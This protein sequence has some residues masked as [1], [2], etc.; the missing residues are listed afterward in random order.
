M[1]EHALASVMMDTR[2][3][4]SVRVEEIVAGLNR[5]QKTIE[6]KYF[7]DAHGS[8]LFEAITELPEYYLTRT[9]MR[10]L[11]THMSEIAALL[12]KQVCVI[13]Y[14]AGSSKKIRLLMDGLSPWAYVPIDISRDFLLASAADLA[15][16]YPALEIFPVCA[17]LSLPLQLP[18]PVAER[19][20]LGFYPGSSIGNFEPSAARAFLQSVAHTLGNGNHLLIGVDRKKPQHLLEAAYNDAAGVTAQFNLNALAHINATHDAN[21]D[22]DAFQHKAVYN[23]ELG[24][25]QMFLESQARQTILLGGAEISFSEGEL[26][27]TENSFKYEAEEFLALAGECGFQ[28]AGHWQDA[29]EYFSLFLLQAEMRATE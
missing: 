4:T 2:P 15:N 27:H 5:P 9:E 1:M 29:N 20:A 8:E 12:G 28:A 13:E 6:P 14:G 17:D 21:F 7:Y 19:P 24:C 18:E 23:H 11:Q 3:N 22:M 26:I 25:I 10:L 16:D